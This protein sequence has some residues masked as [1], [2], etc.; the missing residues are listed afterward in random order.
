MAWEPRSCATGTICLGGAC[1]PLAVP[2]GVAGAAP[3]RERVLALGGEG[4]LNAWGSSGPL[5]LRST[6]RF[7]EVPGD[8]IA[9]TLVPRWRTLCASRAVQ[10]LAEMG[11]RQNPPAY[12]LLAGWLLSPDARRVTLKA[13]AAG[14]AQVWVGTT[15][16]L[17]ASG[18]TNSA[19]LA[20]EVVASVELQPGP[21]ALSV[22]VEQPD[23]K[24]PALLLRVHDGQN[25]VPR[26]LG[27]APRGDGVRCGAAALLTVTPALSLVQGGFAIETAPRLL[28]LA[29]RELAAGAELPTV[30]E[31]RRGGERVPGE[32]VQRA[33]AGAELTGAVGKL[34]GVLQPPR[35]GRY[36][37]RVTA[38]GVEAAKLPL[39]FAG[40]LHDR[41][42]ALLDRDPSGWAVPEASRDSF[43][44]HVERLR[45]A[46]VA[47]ETDR[48]WLEQST[49]EAE[50][51]GAA[52]AN[53]DDIY[54]TRTGYVF[55]AYRSTLDGSL[56]RYVALVPRS[57]R[58][59]GP[60]Q[61]LIMAFHGQGRLPEHGLRTVLGYAPD[62]T[63]T[64]AMAAHHLPTL[65]DV[66]AIVVAPAGYGNAGPRG[67]G[68]EDALRVLAEMKRAYRID[69][70]RVTV[71]GY[72]LGGTVS[73]VL[74]LHYPTEFAAA[75]PLCGY[76][77]LATYES[78]RTV[79]HTPWEETLIARRYIVN[80]AENGLWLPLHIVHG[81][82]DGPQRSQV[83]ADRYQ[84]LGYEHIF[85]VQDDLD[86]NVWDYAYTDRKMIS[87]LRQRRRPAMP[88]RVRLVSGEHRYDRAYWVRLGAARESLKFADIDARWE[89]DGDPLTIRTSNVAE[90]AVDLAQLGPSPPV[91][92]LVDDV[93][94]PIPAGVM[95]VWFAREGGTWRVGSEQRARPGAKRAGVAGPLDDVLRHPLWIV[96]GTQD[97]AQTE[98]NRMTAEHLALYDAYS[99]GR[100]P[101]KP[102]HAVAE[103]DLAARSVVLVGNPKSNRVTALLGDALGVRFETGALLFR[104]K[105]Y[106]G[107]TVG[108]S[109]IRPNPRDAAQY[110]VLHAGVGWRGTLAARHLPQ[111]APDWLVYDERLTTQR[112]EL[113]LG[114][115][116]V[117]DGGFFSDEWK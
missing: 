104:D 26:D 78:V 108:I 74:P 105:R 61:P 102:D 99:G 106:E 101:V 69:E 70:R 21:N 36:E 3:E 4:W 93:E 38:G 31:L 98:S 20:D 87:W 86:H 33:L 60:P 48:G 22:L 82:K 23:D 95:E 46:L 75:S 45:D 42:V 103:A 62:D 18:A 37:V 67:M 116:P 58:P 56:Q 9:G 89:R 112:S 17:D 90:L 5:S 85:D 13:G 12:A 68:E 35:P 53:G 10:P 34:G 51:I 114:G 113:L 64:L 66:G 47:G 84:A 15:R 28:G 65:G 88:R 83:V 94:V 72:S 29:P 19:P 41:V 92:A 107:D 97:P 81:G 77:N 109:V 32:P 27:F 40:A 8:A 110:V 76:P 52:L 43:R 1:A 96:Y 111:L 117:L 11:Q 100:F 71:T 24:P 6:Q 55:R 2:G 44:A 30:L 80:Y 115:R 73:F 79:P 91:R 39:S 16:V 49:A 50:A 54:A 63:M 14:R 59:D 7:Q 25:R 57:Y